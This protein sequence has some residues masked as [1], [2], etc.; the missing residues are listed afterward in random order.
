MVQEIEG[1]E[2][3]NSRRVQNTNSLLEGTV[4]ELKKDLSDLKKELREQKEH[5]NERRFTMKLAVFDVACSI[6]VGIL[7]ALIL[8]MMGV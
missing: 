3:D 6:P 2:F 4:R 8:K 1:A 7:L 5:V